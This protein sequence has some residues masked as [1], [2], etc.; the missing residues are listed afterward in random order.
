MAGEWL[1]VNAA[2]WTEAQYVGALMLEGR[3]PTF[4]E[5]STLA[6][7]NAAYVSRTMA[8]IA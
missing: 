1:P 6:S 7:R 2:L 8:S 3:T 5:W 4:A